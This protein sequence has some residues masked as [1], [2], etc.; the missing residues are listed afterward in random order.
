MYKI[1][2]L[3]YLFIIQS[4]SFVYSDCP[5]DD[6][7]KLKIS[8]GYIEISESRKIFFSDAKITDNK[9]LLKDIKLST[10]E[11]NSI[12]KIRSSSAVI[13]DKTNDVE[14]DNSVVE[15]FEVPIFWIGDIKLDDK[16]TL[17]IPNLGITDSNFDI[18]YKYRFKTD[19][20][21][22]TFEPIYTNGTLGASISYAFQNKKSRLT[23]NTFALNDDR[24]S[25]IYRLKSN[26]EINDG[27][28]FHVDFSDVSGSSLIQNYGYKFLQTNRRALD[29]NKK[30]ELTYLTTNRIFTLSNHGFESLGLLRPINHEKTFFKYEAFYNFF[31]WKLKRSSEYSKFENRQN[32][33]IVQEMSMDNM[34]MGFPY[35]VFKNVDRTSRDLEL[36]KDI[37]HSKAL[38]KTSLAAYWSEYK[39]KDA[40]I[41]ENQNSS[42][43]VIQQILSP[44]NTKLKI[45]Y[46]WSTF[47]DES[48]YPILDSYPKMPSPESNISLN[49]WLGRDRSGNQRKVFLYYSNMYKGLNASFSTN[50]Y[51]K[52]NFENESMIFKKFY[53]KKPVFFNFNKDFG[54]IN[55][56]VK[57]NYSLEKEK[58]M[59]NIFGIDYVGDS[60]SLSIEKNKFMMASYPLMGINNYFLKFRK[61][62]DNFVLFSRTQYSFEDKTLNENV[63]GTE[64]SYDCLKF[65]LSFERAR[66]FPYVPLE[67]TGLSYIDQINLTNTV[68]KNNLS[69][70][71]ELIGLTK[72]LNPLKNILQNGIYN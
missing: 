61:N 14:I 66:F 29:L 44:N 28:N 30:I 2:N 58:F 27:L 71:F 55:I 57:G 31:G 63:I 72:G 36:T 64:W 9:V 12:W 34:R 6:H 23:F 48:N 40:Q 69:F 70:E 53:A 24:N 51:E 5:S 37:L 43:F 35:K 20:S 52:Y 59:S 50:L 3:I 4:C 18:S 67:S 15:I 16:D 60:S 1:K 46:L 54:N 39:I 62:F 19:R 32:A 13:N 41:I 47:N 49:S 11:N 38:L 10:C 42:N 21:I 22:T 17:N 45:G 25:W 8:E 33:P 7:D 56:R 26:Y 68:V 65:R